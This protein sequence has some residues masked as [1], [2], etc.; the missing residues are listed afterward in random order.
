MRRS[1]LIFPQYVEITPISTYETRTNEEDYGYDDVFKEPK[2]KSKVNTK[3]GKAEIAYG[4]PY[5]IQAQVCV[6][7]HDQLE[8]ANHG[9][10]L[11]Y[12]YDITFDMG[13]LRCNNL[14]DTGGNM[15]LRHGDRLTKIYDGCTDRISVHLP[16]NVE[17]VHIKPHGM[18]RGIVNLVTVTFKEISNHVT[19]T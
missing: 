16:D 6:R 8:H 2:L 1:H 4:P 5:R 3:V 17:A 15:L 12:C 18:L 10:V 19:T 9:N 11:G 13:I 7:K 14:I